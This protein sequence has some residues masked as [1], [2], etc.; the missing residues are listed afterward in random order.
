[1]SVN[2]CVPDGQGSKTIE[3][4]AQQIVDLFPIVPK[5]LFTTVSIEQ[6]PQVGQAMID[7]AFR[8]VPVTIRYRQEA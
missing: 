1:M 6:T 2:V 7:N 5:S 8:V 4:L 3:S